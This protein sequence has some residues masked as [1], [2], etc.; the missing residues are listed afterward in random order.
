MGT[1]F[2]SVMSVL[3]LLLLH[4]CSIFPV[5]IFVILSR[6][7]SVITTPLQFLHDMEHGTPKKTKNCLKIFDMIIYIYTVKKTVC[8]IK[9]FDIHTAHKL[10]SGFYDLFFWGDKT[11][12]LTL[13]ILGD[14]LKC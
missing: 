8:N 10:S 13:N 6:N 4:C 14:T 12:V 11:S 7:F 5:F 3:F 9:W 1:T 2:A